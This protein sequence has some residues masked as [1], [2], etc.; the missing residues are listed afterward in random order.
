MHPRTATH[1]QPGGWPTAARHSQTPQPA[2]QGVGDPD[3]EAY[4]ARCSGSLG[5][6]ATRRVLQAR[7]CV[8]LPTMRRFQSLEAGS[9][10]KAILLLL[11]SAA[12]TGRS[13][14]PPPTHAGGELREFRNKLP[15]TI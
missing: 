6:D 8:E 15:Q 4:H 11:A 1:R 7:F 12:V 13:S 14:G 5:G 9:D 3:P 2:P 10:L